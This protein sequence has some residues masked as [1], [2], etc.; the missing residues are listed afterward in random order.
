MLCPSRKKYLLESDFV[1]MRRMFTFVHSEIR[2]PYV[3][4]PLC[5]LDKSGIICS[6][7]MMEPG[8]VQFDE[9]TQANMD[10]VLEEVCAGLPNGGDHE[11]RKF[12]AEQL[13]QCAR[14]GRTTLGELM[15]TARRAI[16]QLQRNQPWRESVP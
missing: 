6:V 16:V 8:M 10:V 12:I 4:S 14:S 7:Q 13:I 3:G 11:S 15:Y 1:A 9:R 2:K 5:V